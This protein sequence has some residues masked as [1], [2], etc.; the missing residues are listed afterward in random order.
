MTE[1]NKKIVKEWLGVA[2][3]ILGI[4]ATLSDEGVCTHSRLEMILCWQLKYQ[5]KV[6]GFA[7]IAP[8]VIYLN[9]VWKRHFLYAKRHLN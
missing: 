3:Q 1:E 6:T 5:M 4:D 8:L 9:L 7:S 2:G